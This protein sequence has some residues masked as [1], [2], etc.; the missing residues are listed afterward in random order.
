M[1]SELSG[2]LDC[3][4][5]LLQDIHAWYQQTSVNVNE[6]VKVTPHYLTDFTCNE[7]AHLFRSTA[8]TSAAQYT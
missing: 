4:W 3:A 7:P 5:T 8:I 1:A 2:K 6:N